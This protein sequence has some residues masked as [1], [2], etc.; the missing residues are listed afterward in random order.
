MPRP[1]SIRP[2][3]WSAGTAI[4]PASKSG[5][6][7][8]SSVYAEGPGGHRRPWTG[9]RA[10]RWLRFLAGHLDRLG[11]RDL[12]WW[13]LHEAVPRAWFGPVFGLIGGLAVGTVAAIASVLPGQGS[14]VSYPVAYGLMFALA[15]GFAIEH[16]I[17][18]ALAGGWAGGVAYALADAPKD[19]LLLGLAFGVANG[20]TI[21]L[22]IGLT[23]L[24]GGRTPARLRLRRPA[25]PG[26]LSLALLVGA[27][28]GLVMGVVGSVA[29]GVTAGLAGALAVGL[30]TG[31][32]IGVRNAFGMPADI[33]QAAD[34]VSLWRAD[35]ATAATLG[36]VFGTAGGVTVGLVAAVVTGVRGGAW[37]GVVYGFV[38]A[39]AGVCYTSWYRFTVARLCL[40]PCGRLPWRTFAF[41]ADAHRRGVLRRNGAVYEFR[42]SR[43][44]DRLTAGRRSVV[45]RRR[46][47]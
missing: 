37:L 42:H 18:G 8:G 41:L 46:G 33:T 36:L 11:T 6:S 22:A 17:V 1:P 21:G 16:R 30:M 19:G 14:Y 7:T 28:V 3:C 25:G 20:S 40:R 24:T 35:R 9:R 4:A 43:L 2:S 29:V 47:P 44:Q 31:L 38:Y 12:A 32:V 10:E 34:P 23:S 39:S 45:V 27:G 26:R 5:S 13:R 15:A